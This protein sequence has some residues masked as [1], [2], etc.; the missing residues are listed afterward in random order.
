MA[1][2]APVTAVCRMVEDKG[3]KGLMATA[4]LEMSVLQPVEVDGRVCDVDFYAVSTVR[5][6]RGRKG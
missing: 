6:S 4:V 3:R 1:T 2:V 5:H